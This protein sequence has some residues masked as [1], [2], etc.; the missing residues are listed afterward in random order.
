[1]P[2]DLAGVLWVDNETFPAFTTQWRPNPQA[3]L[4]APAAFATTP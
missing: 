4:F 2:P 3:L 1:M